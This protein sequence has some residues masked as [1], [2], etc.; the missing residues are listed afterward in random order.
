MKMKP[1]LMRKILVEHEQ[2]VRLQRDLRKSGLKNPTT[3][4]QLLLT[5]L[6]DVVVLYFRNRRIHKIHSLLMFDD[7]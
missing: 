4:N 7:V 6:V 3:I 2:E 1:K 5:Y